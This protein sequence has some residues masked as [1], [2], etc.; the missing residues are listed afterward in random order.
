MTY[1]CHNRAE[2]RQGFF[3]QDGWLQQGQIKKALVKFSP[4]RMEPKCQYTKTELGQKDERCSGCKHKKIF[5]QP[6]DGAVGSLI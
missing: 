5:P 6:V 1:G 3:V 4:F 2:Y